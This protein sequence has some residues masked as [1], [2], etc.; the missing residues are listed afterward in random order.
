MIRSLCIALLSTL[1]LSSCKK[2]EVGDFPPVIS[3]A[4]IFSTG[5]DADAVLTFEYKDENGDLGSE[6]STSSCFL[7]YH[8]LFG[9]DTVDFPEF[10]SSYSLPYLTP[11]AADPSIEGS[12]QLNLE[13]P[14]FDITSDSTWAYSIEIIDRAGN[15]SNRLF[16]PFYNK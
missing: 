3:N 16:T 9:I 10:T 8:E 2:D 1:L 11:N 13:A 5:A 15:R 6:D 4:E 14:F 12:V 7:Y